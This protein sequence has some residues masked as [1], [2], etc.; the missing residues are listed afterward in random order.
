MSAAMTSLDRVLTTLR[1]EEPDRVPLFLLLTMHGAREVGMEL[2]A[3]FGDAHSIAEGQLRLREKYGHDC[4]YSI[5]YAALEV[6]AWGGDYRTLRREAEV[7]AS[8]G[9]TSTRKRGG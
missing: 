5:L 9:F 4:L 6:E 3:Y 8:F 2:E 1:H 7:V